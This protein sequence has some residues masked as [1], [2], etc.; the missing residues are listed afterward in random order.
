MMQTRDERLSSQQRL[1]AA[2]QDEGHKFQQHYLWLEHE[3]PE[4]FL[5][6]VG[7]EHMMLIA[8][9]LMGFHL[10]DY[11]STIKIKRG[12]IVLCLDSA[13]ADPRILQ[14]CA[15]YGI[16]SYR[17]YVSLS[18]LPIPGINKHLRVGL[19][20]FTQY[21]ETHE[22]GF[23]KASLEERRLPV[24]EQTPEITDSESDATM[25]RMDVHFMRT[26]AKDRLVLAFEM[27]FRARS[28]DNCQYEVRYEEDW[29][30]TG[31]ASMQVILAWHNTPRKNFLYRIARMVY[32][33]GLIMKR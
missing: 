14:T 32:R 2:I 30:R 5:S 4:A 6:E 3:M 28:R 21:D 17:V 29:A 16:K 10:Q 15:N 27:L 1:M 23:P 7:Q 19:I 24:R 12:A 26:L 31:H 22:E 11:F 13:D 25:A 20:L 33:H 8:H 18:P 9:N